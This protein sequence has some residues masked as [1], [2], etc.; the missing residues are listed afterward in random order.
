MIWYGGKGIIFAAWQPWRFTV[1]LRVWSFFLGNEGIAYPL[2][3]G[4]G[5]SKLFLFQL[6]SRACIY[7]MKN[8]EGPSHGA[9]LLPFFGELARWSIHLQLTLR[10][11]THV[12]DV[13]FNFSKWNREGIGVESFTIQV[14]DDLNWLHK[15]FGCFFG[16]CYWYRKFE[17]RSFGWTWLFRTKKSTPEWPKHFRWVKYIEVLVL[18]QWLTAQR[19]GDLPHTQCHGL[20]WNLHVLV[21]L[22]ESFG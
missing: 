12:T 7:R 18:W 9:I 15:S 13:Y 3:D 5:K 19:L 10:V 11:K 2:A 14:H 16:D 1:S 6:S 21:G 22:W 17:T 8:H 20:T 4:A